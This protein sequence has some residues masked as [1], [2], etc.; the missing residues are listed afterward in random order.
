MKRVLSLAIVV[1][2]ALVGGC[3]SSKQAPQAVSNSAHQAASQVPT[4]DKVGIDQTWRVPAGTRV[5]V[6]YKSGSGH[7]T[8]N[9]K[10]VS[11]DTGAPPYQRTDNLYTRSIDGVCSVQLSTA[12]FLVKTSTGQT[13]EIGVDQATLKGLYRTTCG[14]GNLPCRDSGGASKT[15]TP[16]VELG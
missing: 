2:A 3:G 7:C 4:E 15:T 12:V 10:I 5:T 13:R 11:F 6:T 16:R 14:A 1:V 9:E 8:K